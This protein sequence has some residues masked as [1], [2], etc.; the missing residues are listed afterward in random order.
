VTAVAES[1]FFAV[2][3]RVS[4]KLLD[5]IRQQIH[6]DDLISIGDNDV[7]TRRVESHSECFLTRAAR[8][9]NFEGH[10]GIVPDFNEGV[11]ARNDQLFP[12]AEIHARDGR[13][14][15][16][17]MQELEGAGKLLGGLLAE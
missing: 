3:Q 13:V 2:F 11:T 17:L 16:L 6:K 7:E 12:E 5:R 10:G 9:V 15:V 4:G 14:V 8:H 1:D